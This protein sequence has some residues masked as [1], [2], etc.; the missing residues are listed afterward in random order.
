MDNIKILAAVLLLLLSHDQTHAAA[1]Q[2]DISFQVDG[3]KV[4]GT[5][6]LPEGTAKPAVILLLHGFKGSRNELQIPSLKVGIYARAADAWAAKGLASLRIDFRG[7]GD[8]DGSFEETTLSGQIKDALAALDFLQTD[9]SID[10]TRIALVGWSQGG[11][12][13]AT[14]AGRTKR[15]LRAVALWN[16]LV[17]PAGTFEAVFG[18]EVVKAGLASGGK[19]I[20]VKLPWGTEVALRTAYFE[21]LF[22]VDPVAE[23][24]RYPGPIFVAVGTKDTL[25]Y[26]QPQSG[27]LLLTYH[28]GPGELWVRPMDHVFNVFDETKTVDELIEATAAFVAKNT[29]P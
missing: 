24:A 23:L 22:T 5:L 18:V 2:K 10:R 17:S 1:I 8:S 20:T 7:G 29:R 11:A 26:P 12:V 3:Q 15:P 25:I 4:V 6:E 9:K 14:V 13:A 27:Q 28:K 21:D 19:S 16:P